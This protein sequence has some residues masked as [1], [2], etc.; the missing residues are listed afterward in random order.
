M[1]RSLNSSLEKQQNI[2]SNLVFSHKLGN[3]ILVPHTSRRRENHLC[4]CVAC[5]F[6]LRPFTVVNSH[7]IIR[8]HLKAF[9]YEIDLLRT[10]VNLHFLLLWHTKSF[11]VLSC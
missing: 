10:Y 11:T 8:F 1:L 6:A 2:E 5:C 7:L 9:L 4:D 3:R